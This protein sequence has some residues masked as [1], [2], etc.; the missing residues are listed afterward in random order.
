[1]VWLDC[2]HCDD[3]RELKLAYMRFPKYKASI[4]VQIELE[5]VYHIDGLA[6]RTE[7]Y[8]AAEC[9]K[10]AEQLKEFEESE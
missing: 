2:G 6:V 9:K 1:M 3:A 7:D 8:V 5:K 10:L 4:A